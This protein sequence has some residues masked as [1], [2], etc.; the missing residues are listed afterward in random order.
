MVNEKTKKSPIEKATEAA[1]IPLED[2]LTLA[3]P[4]IAQAVAK[5]LSEMN[6]P[7]LLAQTVDERVKDRTDAIEGKV[8]A[9]LT[10]IKTATA[11][12]AQPDQ[13]NQGQVNNPFVQ[14]VLASLAQKALG[15]GGSSDGF[16]LMLQR[17]KSFGEAAAV[18]YQTPRLQ[19]MKELIDMQKASYG[20]GLTTEQVVK[21]SE[22]LI[23]GEDI[24]RPPKQP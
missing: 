22:A 20:I 18:L 12:T 24:A 17:M 2:I 1:G 21:G 14:T 9:L 5:T 11:M 8:D 3:Q 19:G 10:E 6:V 4:L 7:E 16:D 15:G 13:S 23:T